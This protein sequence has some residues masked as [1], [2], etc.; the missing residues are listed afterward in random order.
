VNHKAEA[1]MTAYLDA[2]GI[3]N[4]PK[5]PLFRTLDRYRELTTNPINRFDAFQMIT[6]RA[7]D[8]GL[9]PNICCHTFSAT[10]ITTYLQNGGT[11]EK[12]Q[13]MAAHESPRTTKLY[14]RRSTRSP[15]K[16]LSGLPAPYRG[17]E[18]LSGP[19]LAQE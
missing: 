2:V 15:C 9:P 7:M 1:Y 4:D 16:R 17:S 3:K 8:A 5:G 11:L 12:A 14:D 13:A 19:H 10:G 18:R 6:R